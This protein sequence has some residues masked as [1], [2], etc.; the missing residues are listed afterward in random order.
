MVRGDVL[1]GYTHVS[2]VPLCPCHDPGNY[3]MM[4][5]GNS[6]LEFTLICWCGR[7]APGTFDDEA[8]KAAWVARYGKPPAT[9]AASHAQNTDTSQ[10]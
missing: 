1:H 4:E 10:Q 3:V 2:G 6:S 8:E 9:G 5:E 7:R